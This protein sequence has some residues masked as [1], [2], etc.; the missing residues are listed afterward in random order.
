MELDEPVRWAAW[1]AAGSGGCETHLIAEP[2]GEPIGPGIDAARGVVLA[3][4][5]EGGFSPGEVDAARRAGYRPVALG[6]TILRV[7]TAA[8]A[9]CAAVVALSSTNAE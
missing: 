1:L 4:G 9:A 7:E 2:A 5:P 8:L 3:I 6:P